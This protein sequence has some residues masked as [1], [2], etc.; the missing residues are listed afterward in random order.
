MSMQL[1]RL[2]PCFLAGTLGQ[3][4]AE[5]QLFYILQALCQAG[6]APQ[7]LCFDRGEFWEG[8]IRGLGVPVRWVGQSRFRVARLWRILRELR[9]SPA[10]VFQAQHFYVNSY[11]ALAAFL[12]RTKAIGAM[13]SE[14]KVEL[15]GNSALG[16]WLNLHSAPL[17]AA[18][19]RFAI[20]QA[21]AQGVAPSRLYFLPNVVDTERFRPAAGRAERPLT[22]LTVGRLVQL[23]RFDRFITALGRLR[24]QLGRQVQG[25]IVGP[26]QEPELQKA[27]EAQGAKLGVFPGCLR[28]LG[29]VSDMEGL[30]QQADVC[31]LTSNH[32]GTPNVLLEAMACGL[33]VV[34]TRV[35]GVPDIVV[36]GKTGFLVEPED[37]EGLVAALGKLATDVP[38]RI[39]MSRQARGYVEE[40]HALG[41][42][43]AYLT[44][45]Y[46]VALPPQR[47][48]ETS[49]VEGTPV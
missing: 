40:R 20:K 47:A 22:L 35:G 28:F 43:P 49:L 19:T 8:P 48:P 45:L 21:I 39:K 36:H 18:N 46:Q 7:V 31:V 34:A 12:L 9:K 33:P 15:L 42:L 3:G 25:W 5:R 24:A 4:G 27:L 32:E 14:A 41:R 26:G 29:D 38:A 37:I 23:K 2:K 44:N 11:V 6:A 1:A 16:V 30:Y 10:E 13:R 17:I